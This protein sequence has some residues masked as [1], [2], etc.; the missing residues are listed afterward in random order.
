MELEEREEIPWSNLVAEVD[1]ETDRRWYYV[2]IVV[3]FVVLA[4][5]GLRLLSGADEAALPPEPAVVKPSSST[6]STSAEPALVVSQDDLTA[7]EPYDVMPVVARAEWF[8]IDFF[9]VDGSVATIDAIRSALGDGVSDVDLPHER[10]DEPSTFVEWARAVEVRDVSSTSFEVDVAY[11]AI[12]EI[13]DAYER[14]PV[15]FVTL[16]ISMIDGVPIVTGL[17]AVADPWAG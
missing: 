3:G 5:V 15:G 17:P 1:E 16:A 14:S 12:T 9:T 10:P 4:F 2:A 8:V 13:E 6:T 11:R 7:S